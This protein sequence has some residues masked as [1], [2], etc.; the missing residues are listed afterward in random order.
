[1]ITIIWS[2]HILAGIKIFYNFMSYRE[3]DSSKSCSE[4]DSI[5]NLG[6]LKGVSHYNIGKVKFMVI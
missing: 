2:F 1:M 4:E 3:T 6:I 5:D